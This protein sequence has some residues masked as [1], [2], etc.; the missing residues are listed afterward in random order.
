[1]RIIQGGIEYQFTFDIPSISKRPPTVTL[2]IYGNCL[3]LLSLPLATLK[4][5]V[6]RK[7]YHESVLP[8]L[9]NVLTK[10][11]ALQLIQSDPCSILDV[12]RPILLRHGLTVIL[13]SMPYSNTEKSMLVCLYCP[14][15][16]RHSDQAHTKNT[17]P[18]FVHKIETCPQCANLSEYAAH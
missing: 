14:I 2:H 18:Y 17:P 15:C 5:P 13:P 10:P 8:D 1:M 9:W 3:P 12:F 6:T 7:R 16:T 4:K 11:I